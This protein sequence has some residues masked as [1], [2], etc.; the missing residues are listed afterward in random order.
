MSTIRAAFGCASNEE[1]IVVAGGVSCNEPVTPSNVLN[2]IE[3]L[4]PRC[5][6]DVKS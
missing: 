3:I 4:D 2:S 6:H 1:H 5:V